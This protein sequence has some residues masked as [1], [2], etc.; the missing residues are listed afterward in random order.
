MARRRTWTLALTATAVHLL[1]LDLV[2]V[3]VALP[4]MRRDLDANLP[5]V[6]WA[7]DAYA[8][9]LASLLLTA[10]AL[11]DRFGRRRVFLS[12]LGVF[13]G[14]SLACG[15]APS[16]LIL[17]VCR[18]VQGI[19]AAMLYGSASPLLA[20]VFPT[21]RER[22]RA[23]GVFAASA[24]AATVTAPL[25]GGLLT[26]V[27]G[28]RAIFVASAAVATA[29]LAVGIRVVDESR[30][31]HPRP[32]D[33]RATGYLTVSLIAAMWALIEAWNAPWQAIG[34]LA[35]AVTA[36]T[37]LA[38]RRTP[39]PMIDFSLLRDGLYAANAAAAFAFHVAGAGTMV[40]FALY[41]Q[42][43]MG[44]RPAEMGLWF[45]AYSLPALAIPLLLGPV[46]HRVPP[47]AAVAAGPLLTTGACVSLAVTYGQGSFPAMVPSL[48]VGGI[49]AGIGTLVSSQ[50]ALAA[51]PSERAGVAAGITS[52]A[53]Q[54]GVA[55]GVAALGVP[56]WVDGLGAV[57][58][59]AA[60][61]AALGALPALL[62]PAA[63]RQPKPGMQA[64]TRRPPGHN[65]A[66]SS[67][68]Q[69]VD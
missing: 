60:V 67:P 27:F 36:G 35:L 23:L 12:G 65:Q 43:P 68:S 57:L 18:G 25:L 22:N 8:L 62:L 40:Y 46:V 14:T 7:I 51:A 17:D 48:V 49:G 52:T 63:R 6:Q 42:G 61:I 16:A 55:A 64:T 45:L 33:L 3:N 59:V 53:K 9:A 30:A 56:Y 44:A 37:R 13:G 58:I 39:D 5:Q 28:W 41:V 4:D 54:L 34:A 32:L 47:A 29:A 24:G 11:A 20:A 10:G 69:P 15:L 21:G 2:G 19:G 50:V 31:P 66:I 1:I 38:L 26:E